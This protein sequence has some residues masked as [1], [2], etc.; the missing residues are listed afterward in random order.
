MDSDKVFYHQSFVPYNNNPFH[1]TPKTPATPLQA[2]GKSP[3]SST[4][5]FHTLP[6]PLFTIV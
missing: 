2:N 1:Y 6:H 3:S 5:H 4:K